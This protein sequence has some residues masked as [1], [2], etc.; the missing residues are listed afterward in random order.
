M[1]IGEHIQQRL[2]G[3][4]RREV[5]GVVVIACLLVAGVAFW[6][7][8]SLPARV[9]I[10]TTGVPTGSSGPGPAPSA[11]P[12]PTPSP[13][14]I[15]VDVAGWVRHPGVFRLHEGDRIVD[16]LVMAGGAK[17]HADLR[18]LKLAALLVDGQQIIVVRRGPGGSGPTSSTTS[19]AGSGSATGGTGADG[20]AP[21]NLNTATL[22]ELESLPG[23][24]PVLGQHIIDYREQHGPFRTVEDL[25]N[26]SGIGDKR[27]A[28]LKPHITV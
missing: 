11:G 25:L 23:I 16:A 17:P 22:D 7:V 1:V 9:Q 19:V 13:G 12:S 20:T 27:F 24:G 6:Y 21:V 5:V 2:R 10:T 14:V 26:V 3:L 4:D 8:R 18:S 28:D 15:V